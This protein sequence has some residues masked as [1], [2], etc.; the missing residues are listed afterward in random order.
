M[1]KKIIALAVAGLMS[2]AAFAQSNVTVYGLLDASYSQIRSTGDKTQ[3]NIDGGLLSGSRLGFKG[4][5]DLGNGLKAMFVLEY[6]LA[7][8][9]NSAVGTAQPGYSSTNTR[10]SLVGLTGGFGTV[11]AGRAQTTAYDWSIAVDPLGGT[12]LDSTAKLGAATVISGGSGGRADNAFA[13]VSP[14]FGGFTVAYNHARLTESAGT[15]GLKD[16]TAH[17]FSATYAN[18][19]IY[20]G[21]VYV[22]ANVEKSSTTASTV[23]LAAVPGTASVVTTT[24]TTAATNAD[25]K[26]WGLGGSYDLG[27]AKLFASYQKQDTDAAAADNK[28]QLGVSA[29]V[30]AGS[31]VFTYADSKIKSTAAQDDSKAFGLAYIHN[32]SKRTNVY[33]G[34]SKVSNDG[35]ATRGI[36]GITT[37]AGGS[38]SIIGAGLRHSF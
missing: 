15:D 20:A 12:G 5:E 19:P 28:W 29:P 23:T 27:V 38:A 26:E 35:T 32:L 4:T 21:F 37:A 16:N 8:D 30:G 11:V 25:W 14:S 9:G 34:Y 13:Y 36:K 18:G 22:D 24:T 6:S 3:S 7:N 31:V 10:Q 2:G 1:Q 33:A 17:L